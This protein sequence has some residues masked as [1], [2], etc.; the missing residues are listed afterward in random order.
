[1]KIDYE[2]QSREWQRE[3]PRVMEW[4][5]VPEIRRINSDGTEYGKYQ[6]VSMANN[7][8]NRQCDIAVDFGSRWGKRFG[9]Y[10]RCG[11]IPVHGENLCYHHG[12]PKRMYEI[13]RAKKALDKAS[14]RYSRTISAM[15]D[16]LD[17]Y[18]KK[19]KEMEDFIKDNS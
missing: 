5:D 7:P 4:K 1:M 19:I 15:V 11:A 16:D 3:Y 2:N 12:G 13:E 17:S 10:N 18:K 9:V 14:G 6:V 8:D